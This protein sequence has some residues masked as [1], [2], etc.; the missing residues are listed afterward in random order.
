MTALNPAAV[1][2]ADRCPGIPVITEDSL[3]QFEAVCSI[4]RPDL[5]GWEVTGCESR[6]E[7]GAAFYGHA[8]RGA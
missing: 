6:A 1:A 5:C 8:L 4:D 7:A 3:G 2:H